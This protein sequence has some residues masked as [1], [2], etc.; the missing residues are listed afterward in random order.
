MNF[1][2]P[3]RKDHLWGYC[4]PEKKIVIPCQYDRTMEFVNGIAIVK[5]DGKYGAINPS[6]E[7]I[8]PIKWESFPAVEEALY[9]PP[10]DLYGN[11]LVRDADE[12]EEEEMEGCS[13]IQWEEGTILDYV[14]VDFLFINNKYMAL[15][16]NIST[17]TYDFLS[18]FLD[19]LIWVCKEGKIG[20]IDPTGKQIIPCMYEEIFPFEDDEHDRYYTYVKLNDKWGVIHNRTNEQYWED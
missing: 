12:E 13:S 8:T 17:D 11:L 10:K 6:G 18:D 14:G 2:L 9:G 7:I 5:R 1:I 16:E 15:D 4:T 3:Y 20:A 19:G